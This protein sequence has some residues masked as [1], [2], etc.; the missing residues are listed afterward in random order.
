[1]GQK[2]TTI[3]GAEENKDVASDMNL[4]VGG[5]LTVGCNGLILTSYGGGGGQHCDIQCS[6]FSIVRA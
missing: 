3:V 4:Q 5:T 2:R 1:V 6:S